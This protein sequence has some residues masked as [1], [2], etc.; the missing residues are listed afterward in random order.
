MRICNNAQFRLLQ[1]L[2]ESTNF[3]LKPLA[4][5]ALQGLDC[6][7][8][9]WKKIHS[10][11]LLTSYIAD[12]LEFEEIFEVEGG[13]DVSATCH[14]CVIQND[15]FGSTTKIKRP[16]LKSCKMLL[17]RFHAGSTIFE[18]DPINLSMF[19]VSPVLHTFTFV[20]FH[21]CVYLYVVFG[22]NPWHCLSL[23]IS[24][25]LKECFIKY[26]LNTTQTSTAMK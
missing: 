4:N 22:N 20:G 18:K 6:K 1:V 19:S 5:C 23:G 21:S 15:E 16:S 11:F 7:T 14:Y 8:Y 2:H 25:T 12:F 9:D 13:I 24:R 17:I 26:L 10:H 3:C